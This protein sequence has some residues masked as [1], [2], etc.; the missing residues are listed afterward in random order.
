MMH[1]KPEGQRPAQEEQAPQRDG[2][3]ATPGSLQQVLG[4]VQQDQAGQPQ[5]CEDFQPLMMGLMD[6]E[7]TPAEAVAVNDHLTRCRTCRE[8][9]ELLRESSEKLAAIS[10]VE[11]TDEV[12]EGFWKHPYNALE[13]NTGI[14]L[15]VGSLATLLL[16]G[17]YLF[18]TSFSWELFV[19]GGGEVILRLAMAALFLGLLLVCVSVLRQRLR[20]SKTDPYKDIKR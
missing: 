6:Q 4:R 16:Y 7:L 20:T 9:Y 5:S 14:Y 17:G 18:T 19:T 13:R 10:F 11:P 12:L 2:V 1:E 15:V 3:I 8:E